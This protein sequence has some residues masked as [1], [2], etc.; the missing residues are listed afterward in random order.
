M[1][2]LRNPN[3]KPT[4]PGAVLR[5]DLLPE[6]GVTHS[7]L[8]SDLGLREATLCEILNEKRSLTVELA[9]PIANVFRGSPE[10]WLQVQKAAD[11][12]EIQRQE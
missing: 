3:R 7:M 10:S 2:S 5:E 11:F 1:K 8:A 12:W 4:H 9:V 6:S